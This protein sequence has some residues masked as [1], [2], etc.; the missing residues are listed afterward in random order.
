MSTRPAADTEVLIVGAGPTGLSMAC[1][2][3]RHGVG[4]VIVDQAEGLT[5]YSKA[6]GVQ[7]RTL[8]IYEQLGLA[9]PAL[10][11]GS[12]ARRGRLVVGGQVRGEIDL[13][14]I[15]RGLSAYPY[16]LMLE[17][18]KNERLLHDHLQAGG[19]AV[20]WQT[21]LVGLDHGADDASAELRQ[22]DGTTQTLR[23][24]YV[25]GC[26]GP[27]STVRHALG[28]G[29]VGSTFERTFYVADA[30]IDW[31]LP[32]DALHICFSD[33]AFVV[34]F[35]LEGERRYRIVGVVPQRLE[36]RDGEWG[37]EA[38][39]TRIAGET[40]ID[41]AIHDVEWFSTYKVHTRHAEHFSDGCA[42]IAGDA[43]HVHTPAGAQ[44]MNTGIQD[45]Y[46]LAWKLAW[47]LKGRA[48]PRLLASY[49]EERLA[50]ARHLLST[51]D[52]LFEFTA[53]TTWWLG[54]LRSR[55][56]P[57]IAGRLFKFGPVRS[58]VF[59]L[60]SQTGISYRDASLS[61]HDGDAD[62]AVRAGDRMPYFAL[63][64]GSVYDRLREPRFQLLTFSDAVA[65]GVR[66][67]ALAAE[68]AGGL[69]VQALPLDTTVRR[70][71]GSQR[72]FCALL[73]PDNHLALL[74]HDTS[75]E[76][77]RA[78]LADLARPA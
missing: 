53:G 11:Q 18:S 46:N 67:H 20:S 59:P 72:P 41:L 44:G 40:G 43:A 61:Q 9:E 48:D 78:Y 68:F 77:A 71:F 38:I 30:R 13:S 24:R 27:H 8:E 65:D 12:I 19:G 36:E 23:A 45:G 29:F 3:Q 34:F 21:T 1:Q 57:P 28:L 49:D 42:F 32:H 15:G 75:G 56:L 22:A 17:Q 31:A 6:I 55:V 35:P 26:D 69:S 74:S 14:D 62:F 76:P 51:T 64:G 39:E 5:P 54:F 50:N 66:L 33:D 7:A 70:S 16:V 10:A 58:F 63:D 52:R 73:R 2:L 4:F 25:V 47:V 37:F 60:L